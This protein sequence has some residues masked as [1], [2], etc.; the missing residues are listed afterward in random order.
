MQEVGSSAS[1][2]LICFVTDF[3]THTEFLGR[4]YI[5]GME[6]PLVYNRC[7]NVSSSVQDKVSVQKGVLITSPLAKARCSGLREFTKE[8]E[9]IPYITSVSAAK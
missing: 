5:R 4:M 2:N 9:I 3:N 6:V 7:L 1:R 8:K